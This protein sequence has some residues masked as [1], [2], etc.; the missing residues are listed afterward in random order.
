LKI[1]DDWGEQDTAAIMRGNK[2]PQEG[3]GPIRIMFFLGPVFPP[4]KNGSELFFSQ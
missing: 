3:T 4:E 2:L 1:Q